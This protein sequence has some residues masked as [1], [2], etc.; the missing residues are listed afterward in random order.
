MIVTILQPFQSTEF[1]YSVGQ[2]VDIPENL[3]KVFIE[4]GLVEPTKKE[5]P[6]EVSKEVKKVSPKK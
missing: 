1:G 2:E 4:R 5:T 3:A 6:K